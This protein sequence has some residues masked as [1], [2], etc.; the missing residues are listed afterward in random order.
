MPRN[1]TNL[2]VRLKSRPVGVPEAE[3]FELVREPVGEPGVGQVLIRIAFVAVEPAMRGWVN[4]AANYAQPV[5]IGAVM[6]S[7]A[8]G[9]I[10]ASRSPLWKEGELVTG[11]FGW[12]QWALVDAGAI[13]RRLDPALLGPLPLSAALGVLGLN[14]VTAYFGLLE[15]GQ[16]R[17]GQTVVVSS[18]AGSVGSCVGQIA[19]LAG[20]RT[21]AIAGG[22]QKVALARERFGFDAAVDYKAEGFEAALRGACPNGV[23]IYFDNTSGPISDAVAALINIRARLVICGTVAHTNWDP[24]P[25]GPRVERRLMV[26]RSRMEG[27][28]A[29]DYQHRW[30]EAY[31]QLAR[32]LQQGHIQVVEDVLDGLE[33]AP[34]SIAGLYRGE[35][36]GKRVIRVAD[37]I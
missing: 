7:Y 24:P 32:W 4:A 6:K 15:V 29:P 34:G 28:V 36:L 23:D 37:G 31:R 30:D 22:A 27:F 1:D 9:R 8:V 26:T 25:L 21:V 16:P 11:L 35:N 3:H 2:Q 10:V 20:C 14:G 19:K 17:P 13:E 12:Q 33:Q 18:G 5:A